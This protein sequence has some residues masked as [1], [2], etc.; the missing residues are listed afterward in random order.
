MLLHSNETLLTYICCS[1]HWTVVALRLTE[2]KNRQN[3]IN[4]FLGLKR[5]KFDSFLQQLALQY[6]SVFCGIISMNRSNFK[7]CWC[8]T[9]TVGVKLWDLEKI[10]GGE[11]VFIRDWLFLNFCWIRLSWR[12]SR[13]HPSLILEQHAH[14]DNESFNQSEVE[15]LRSGMMNWLRKNQKRHFAICSVIN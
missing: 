6:R 3:Y 15:P 9:H 11:K 10:V 1:D 12:H 13:T 8:D 4:I 2:I 14:I 5:I 7:K